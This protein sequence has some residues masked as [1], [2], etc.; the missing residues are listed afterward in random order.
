MAVG[1]RL[2]GKD[3]NIRHWL[4]FTVLIGTVP[5]T[6]RIAMYF[7]QSNSSNIAGFSSADMLSFTSVLTTSNLYIVHSH[8]GRRERHSEIMIA[9]SWVV[10]ALS[11]CL[12]G[13]SLLLEIQPPPISYSHLNVLSVILA[14][15]YFLFSFAVWYRM[16]S[17]GENK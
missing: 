6:L 7:V 1:F 17:L 12:F 11:S 3:M 4:L 5:F 16:N 9:V 2:L 8:Q 15:S 14:V 10:L 13:G